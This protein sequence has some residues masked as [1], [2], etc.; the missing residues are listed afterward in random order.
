VAL[1]PRMT[2]KRQVRGQHGRC[3]VSGRH[4]HGIVGADRTTTHTVGFIDELWFSRLGDVL[5]KHGTARD[6]RRIWYNRVST[7]LDKGASP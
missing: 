4:T 5:P 1:L 2:S 6:C 7:G 3:N